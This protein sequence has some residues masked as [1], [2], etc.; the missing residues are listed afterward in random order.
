MV[1][2]GVLMDCPAFRYVECATDQIT[3]ET[4][5]TNPTAHQSVRPLLFISNYLI[6]S[7][8]LHSFNN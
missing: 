3:A 2:L 4:I 8:L 5:P 6:I 7:H 1:S